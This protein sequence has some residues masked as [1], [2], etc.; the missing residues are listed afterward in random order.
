[1]YDQYIALFAVRLRMQVIRVRRVTHGPIIVIER[2]GNKLI[3]IFNMAALI[4]CTNR[5]RGDRISKIP[6]T[7]IAL[8]LFDLKGKRVFFIN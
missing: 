4:R 7:A 2:S 3:F 6:K 5:E 1:M 8:E